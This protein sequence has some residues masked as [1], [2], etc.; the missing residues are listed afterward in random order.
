MSWFDFA[1]RPESI[2]WHPTAG[3]RGIGWHLRIETCHSAGL[4]KDINTTRGKFTILQQFCNLIPVG[5]LGSIVRRH[6]S[7]DQSR[8]FSH[9]S[10]VVALMYSKTVHCFGPNDLCDQLHP[11]AL[12]AAT[13]ATPTFR[14]SRSHANTERPATIW[15]DPFWKALKHLKQTSPGFG[16]RRYPGRLG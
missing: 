8:R 13:G 4:K 7:E 12:I 9:W 6:N 15:E 2:H 1:E 5:V 10:Q 3:K 14:N 11:G 16:R